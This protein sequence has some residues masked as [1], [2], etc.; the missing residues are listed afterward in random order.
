[1]VTHTEHRK[2]TFDDVWLM[3]QE[4][5]KQFQE[6][7][8]NTGKNFLCVNFRKIKSDSDAL[9]AELIYYNETTKHVLVIPW[10]MLTNLQNN[11][12]ANAI[13]QSDTNKYG[14]QPEQNVQPEH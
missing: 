13:H 12:N 8:Y 4:T 10:N 5:N 7:D 1:M 2:P 14:E 6:T 11:I 9:S 3:F